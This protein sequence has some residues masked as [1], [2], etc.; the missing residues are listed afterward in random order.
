MRSTDMP[1]TA[2]YLQEPFSEVSQKLKLLR[3]DQH[4]VN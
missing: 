2:L 1:C 4:Q 3:A